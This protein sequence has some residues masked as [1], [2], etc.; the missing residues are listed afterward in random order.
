MR[1]K[2]IAR[3]IVNKILIY[4]SFTNLVYILCV[5]LMFNESEYNTNVHL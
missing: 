5:Q 2:C 4:Y 3:L 1:K